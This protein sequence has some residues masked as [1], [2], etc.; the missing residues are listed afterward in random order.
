MKEMFPCTD[1]FLLSDDSSSKQCFFLSRRQVW[2]CKPQQFLS[3]Y[4]PSVFSHCLPLCLHRCRVW[5]NHQCSGFSWL[6]A[7]ICPCWQYCPVLL[8]FW[9]FLLIKYWTKGWIFSLEAGRLRDACERRHLH[10]ALQTA[11]DPC[12]HEESLPERYQGLF[13]EL[14]YFK[15]GTLLRKKLLIRTF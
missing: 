9:V 6:S 7:G 14:I 8:I 13:Q 12:W 1:R 3:C 15:H 11:A 4:F 10:K 5:P 2:C